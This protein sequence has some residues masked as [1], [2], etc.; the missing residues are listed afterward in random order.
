M[1]YLLLLLVM[2]STH[3]LAALPSQIEAD[4]LLLQ[5]KSRL[6]G[7]DYAAAI[8]SLNAAA[9]LNVKMPDTFFF[10]LGKA[11][12]GNKEWALARQ[13]FEKYLEKSGEKAKFYREALEGINLAEAEVAKR[14][15][16]IDKAEQDYAKAQTKYT[17]DMEECGKELERRLKSA[18]RTVA[19]LDAECEAYSRSHSG[20]YCAHLNKRRTDASE[21]LDR[22][23]YVSARSWC[24]DRV[25][26]PVAPQISVPLPSY[27][28]SAMPLMPCDKPVW[29]R[30]ALKNELQGTVKLRFLIDTQGRVRDSGIIQSSGH[31][32]LDDAA[33]VATSKCILDVAPAKRSPEPEWVQ[34]DYVWTIN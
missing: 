1:R 32:M 31:K 7:E 19:R 33:L 10:H 21:E 18:E 26:V 25:K 14:R 28:R 22:Y 5:A 24:K 12:A 20:D 29:P 11:Y 17:Q 4:R 8:V 27:F 15:A 6:E 9:A 3:V 2:L 13:S 23:Q 16:A 30:E 34:L